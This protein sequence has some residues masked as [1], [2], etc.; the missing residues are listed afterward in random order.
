MTYLI[1]FHTHFD[2]LSLMKYA[3]TAGT[4][5][6]KPVPRQLSSSCGTCVLFTPA[7]PDAL[8]ELEQK[9]IEKIYRLT[10]TGYE[11][12]CEKE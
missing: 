4:A 2:A 8:Q 12:V 7:Q 6:M 1:T 3:K 9:N 10:E 5:T 11:L